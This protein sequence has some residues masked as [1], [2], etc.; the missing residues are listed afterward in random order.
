MKIPKAVVD[1]NVFVSA[2]FLKGMSSILMEKWKE[3]KFVLV[4]SPEIFDEYFEIIARPKFNQEEKDIRELADLLIEKGVAIEPQIALNII[5]EDPDDNKFLECAVAGE[6][7]F[8]IS[9]DRHLLSLQEYKGT[10]IVKIAQFI[11]EIS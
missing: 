7:D 2:A 9:G 4:F 6:A 10:R 3:D 8:I 5:K 1:T 11:Q